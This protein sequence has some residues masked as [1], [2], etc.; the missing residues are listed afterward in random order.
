MAASRLALDLFREEKSRKTSGTMVPPFRFPNSICTSY[1][2][3]FVFW[4]H[5]KGISCT[6]FCNITAFRERSIKLNLKNSREN[7]FR[8][9]CFVLASR[10]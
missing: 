1:S 8:V 10:V 6:F 3:L 7:R 9:D 2:Q 5:D 4:T